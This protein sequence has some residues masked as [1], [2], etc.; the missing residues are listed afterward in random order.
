VHSKELTGT[1]ADI[2]VLGFM[3]VVNWCSR[4]GDCSNNSGAFRFITSSS[5]SA[6]ELGTP[7]HVFG[8]PLITL[9][10]CYNNQPTFIHRCPT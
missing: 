6:F 10:R 3:M 7:Y 9:H 8:S 1:P 2:K 5:S 4:S